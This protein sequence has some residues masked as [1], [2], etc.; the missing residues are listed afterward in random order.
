M[1]FFFFFCFQTIYNLFG[2]FDKSNKEKE[3]FR[4]AMFLDLIREVG[5]RFSVYLSDYFPPNSLP[6][7]LLNT[8]L[9]YM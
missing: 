8:I 5:P 9:Y 1:F 6:L 4:S 2:G 3:R 7:F